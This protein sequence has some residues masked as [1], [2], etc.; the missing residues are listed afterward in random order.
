M[1]TN[2]TG[3]KIKE[4]IV[5]SNNYTFVWGR[6]CENGLYISTCQHACASKVAFYLFIVACIITCMRNHVCVCWFY[7][8]KFSCS[9]YFMTYQSLACRVILKVTFLDPLHSSR[10]LVASSNRKMQI[11]VQ[12]M[13]TKCIN[14]TTPSTRHRH[15][16][17][18][19]H[20][21]VSSI[22]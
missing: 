7:F 15:R 5:H 9:V 12:Q 18:H 8:L 19:E 20:Y 4:K 13:H 16:Q 22:S 10:C 17:H 3:T 6:M 14:K 11:E 21:F 2:D 1:H